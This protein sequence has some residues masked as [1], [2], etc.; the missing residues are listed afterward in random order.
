MLEK[1]SDN[2]LQGCPKIEQM[3]SVRIKPKNNV[4]GYCI[5]VLAQCTKICAFSEL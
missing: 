2:C 1:Q 5:G 3:L 4:F